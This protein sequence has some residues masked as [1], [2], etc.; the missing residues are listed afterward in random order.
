M[1]EL[2]RRVAVEKVRSVVRRI[3]D[4]VKEFLAKLRKRQEK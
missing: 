3:A 4:L 2:E 1:Y